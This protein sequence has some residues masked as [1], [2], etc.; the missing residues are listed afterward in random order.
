MSG[1]IDN[2]VELIHREHSKL[3]GPLED[4]FYSYLDAGEGYSLDWADI[5]DGDPWVVLQHA[6]PMI[7]SLYESLSRTLK[8]DYKK[9]DK[10]IVHAFDQILSEREMSKLRDAEHRQ[11]LAS[12]YFRD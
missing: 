3:K 4:A 7:R 8:Q 2:L 10:A 1:S 6:S 5:L 12:A 11:R 9:M